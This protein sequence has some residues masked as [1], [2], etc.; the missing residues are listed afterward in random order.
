MKYLHK[1]IAQAID[2]LIDL[3]AHIALAAVPGAFDGI[4]VDANPQVVVGGSELG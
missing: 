4:G 1:P 2:R 3:G